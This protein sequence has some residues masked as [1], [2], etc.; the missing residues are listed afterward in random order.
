[1]KRIQTLR[2]GLSREAVLAI[3]LI[4]AL[5]CGTPSLAAAS[6]P[7]VSYLGPA[8]TYTEQAAWQLF[9]EGADF[10]PRETVADA[11]D[12]VRSGRAD[13]AVIPQENTIGGPVYDYLDELLA[14]AELYVTGEVELPIRQ[15]L[16]APVGTTL[17]TI[18]TV[19]SHK[20]GIA[21]GRDWLEIHLPQAQVVEVSSTAEGARLAAE[22]TDG[23][24]AAIASTQAARLYGLEVLA[25]SIQQSDAN[26]TRFYLVSTQPVLP[27]SPDRMTFSATGPAHALP[28]LL[29]AMDAQGLALVSL[30]DRPAKTALGE[31]VYLLECSGGGQEAFARLEEDCG[32]LSLRFLGSYC[33]TDAA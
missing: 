11:V 17:A 30:H 16:V 8:G 7:T 15:A 24:Q 22:C 1:M 12:D 28:E 4:C 19:Y 26:V 14:H 27:E 21:Q 6:M 33:L 5:L 2:H 31:Y 13:C 18:Q 32:A 23:T 10:Q 9:P 25:E 29:A 20:Q 3:L